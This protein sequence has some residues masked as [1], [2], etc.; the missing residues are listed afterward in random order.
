MV[1]A[2]HADSRWAREREAAYPLYAPYW[3]KCAAP[4]FVSQSLHPAR[5]PQVAFP[6]RHGFADCPN[7]EAD[8]LYSA[9]LGRDSPELFLAPCSAQEDTTTCDTAV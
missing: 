4:Y 5:P 2:C 8:N 7:A 9:A 3:N 1:N 6:E